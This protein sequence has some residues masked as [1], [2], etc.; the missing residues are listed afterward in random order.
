VINISKNFYTVQ[1]KTHMV[2]SSDQLKRQLCMYDE[3]MKKKE[4]TKKKA[5]IY[6]ATKCVHTYSTNKNKKT[7]V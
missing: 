1:K 3:V 6:T 5:D 2:K 7:D 4:R